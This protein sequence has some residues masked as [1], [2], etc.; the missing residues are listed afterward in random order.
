MDISVVIPVYN[1]EKNVSILIDKLMSSSGLVGKEWEV[2]LIDDGSIDGTFS[3]LQHLKEK[4]PQIKIIHF[5]INAG[6]A[7]AYSAGFQLASG[8][9]IL[10]MDGDLQ[11]DPAEISSFLSTLAKGADL[12]VGW[13]YKGKGST[14]KTIPSKIFN[15]LL[16]ILTGLK[17]NDSNCPFR[18][19]KK[20]VAK[21][22]NIYGDLYRFIPY[23][24][25]QKGYKVT[26]IKVENYP[27]QFGSSK[28][29][30]SR[31]FN[32]VMDLM[33][34]LFISR[35]SKRPLHFFGIPGLAALFLGFFIDAFLVL[36]GFFITGKIGHTALLIMGVM[37]IIIGIQFISLGLLGELLVT[38]KTIELKDL[39]IKDIVR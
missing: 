8:N 6:K 7:A 22:L 30:I 33:T 24:A 20:E 11:D 5:G 2:I 3:E 19:M 36:K 35:Y 14:G 34:V 18:A 23:L 26:E 17:I 10:T 4:I 15:S 1:E 39:P 16:S 37:L 38:A 31:L 21:G 9:V 29:G 32:G 25:F 28:Y 12:V 27:R 13:K